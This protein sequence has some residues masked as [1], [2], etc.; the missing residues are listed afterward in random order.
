MESSTFGYFLTASILLTLA[1]GPDILYLLTK[2]LSDGA[3]AGIILACGLVS[4]IVFHTMLVMV[5]VAAFIKS[6]ATALLLL[7]IFGAAYLLFLAFGAFKAARAGKKQLGMRNA[8]CEIKSNALR[9]PHY[10]LRIYKR[11]VLMNV[12][13]PKVLL[14]FLAFLPQFV[15]L[16]SSGASLRIL[17]LGVVFAAQALIIFSGVAFFAGHVRNLLLRKKNIGQLL[18]FLEAAV[19]TLIALSLILFS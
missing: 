11:G 4:G 13:N 1:P 5:G 8:Q 15:N 9:I 2:S 3:K 19:L 12:L 7:K 6:S 16:S 14:F 18:N 10:A 17:F